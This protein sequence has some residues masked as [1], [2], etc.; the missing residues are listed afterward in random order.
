MY[1]EEAERLFKTLLDVDNNTWF[2]RGH[3]DTEVPNTII[4]TKVNDRVINHRTAASQQSSTK[5]DGN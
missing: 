3:G 1:Q 4:R 5:D 2:T